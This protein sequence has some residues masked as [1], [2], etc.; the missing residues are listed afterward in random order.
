MKTKTEKQLER[1]IENIKENRIKELEKGF[2]QEENEKKEEYQKRI[3]TY[4]DE[5]KEDFFDFPDIAKSY[6]KLK[7]KL[8]GYRKAKEEFNKK[9]C[10]E[11]EKLIESGKK[12]PDCKREEYKCIEAHAILEFLKKFQGGGE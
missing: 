9:V 4:F 3:E 12:C 5:E 2:P 8:E 11:I 1:E 7:A 10:E 6:S